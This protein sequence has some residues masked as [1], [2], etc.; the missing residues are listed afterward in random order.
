MHHLFIIIIIFLFTIFYYPG[1]LNIEKISYYNQIELTFLI[2]TV[3]VTMVKVP[4]PIFSLFMEDSAFDIPLTLDL[5]NRKTTLCIAIFWL[6]LWYAFANDLSGWQENSS[7]Q[8]FGGEWYLWRTWLLCNNSKLLA[9]YLLNFSTL[10]QFFLNFGEMDG[11][12]FDQRWFL[13][14][15]IIRWCVEDYKKK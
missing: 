7:K 3:L 1:L 9:K 5:L 2:E 14:P 12:F 4:I 6:R 13:F 8:I 15:R 10:N 11:F